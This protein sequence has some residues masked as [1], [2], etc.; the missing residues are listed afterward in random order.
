MKN[1]NTDSGKAELGGGTE[2]DV[3]FW[4]SRWQSGMTG[5]DIGYASPPITEYLKQYDNK[6]AAVLIPGCGNAYEAAYMI[7]N[8]FTNVTLVDISDVA[9]ATLKE[10]FKG[11]Q[12][13]RILCE[14]FFMHRGNYDLI[15]EQTFFCAQVLSRREEYVRKMHS[16][17]NENG[18]LV[19][20]LF[21]VHFGHSGPPFGGEA[22]EYRALFEPFF[23]I[24][25]MEP[26][27]N[28]IHPRDGAE[29]FINLV[30][31]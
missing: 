15:V 10:K 9:V 18:R 30:K 27:Y 24:E 4:N 22:S 29:L 31:K 2:L 26:C 13:V 12:Q 8:G 20:V 21:G 16:L 19:G 14:D 28:S 7:N 5:W 17:L 11:L 25:K 1:T 3:T 23:H 6:N